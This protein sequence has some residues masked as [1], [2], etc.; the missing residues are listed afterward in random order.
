MVFRSGPVIGAEL[1]I[2]RLNGTLQHRDSTASLTIN[3]DTKSQ[4]HWGLLAGYGLGRDR[5]SM[6][7]GYVSEVSRDFD[8]SIVDNGQHYRQGDGQ[9]LLRFGVGVEQRAGRMG[10]IRASLGTSRADFG[11]R[12]TNMVPRRPLELLI[13][14]SLIVR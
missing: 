8:V 9:G 14:S 6:I 2:G 5:S 13:G 1:G 12:R 10:A 3:Y 4:R 7:F 11:D